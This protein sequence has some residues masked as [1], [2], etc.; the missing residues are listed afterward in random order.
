[1]T[2][3]QVKSNFR[4]HGQTISGWARDNGY[5]PNTVIRVLN[6]FDKCHYGRAHEIAVK[7]GMKPASTH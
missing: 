7:L 4:K 2:A 5:K 3:E 1:M 6:G